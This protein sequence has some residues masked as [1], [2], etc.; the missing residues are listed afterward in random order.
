TRRVVRASVP[1]EREED[2]LRDVFGQG[3]VRRQSQRVAEH[4][5]SMAIVEIRERLPVPGPDTGQEFGLRQRGKRHEGRVILG[6]SE[7]YPDR[8]HAEGLRRSA[9]LS[10]RNRKRAQ[11]SPM[12]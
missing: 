7:G 4:E 12:R 9:A 3:P 10:S 5:R 1:E 8:S 11:G 6:L 2:L